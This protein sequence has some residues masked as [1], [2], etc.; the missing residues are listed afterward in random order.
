MAISFSY[1]FGVLEEH[2]QRHFLF[3]YPML[4]SIDLTTHV[5]G[6]DVTAQASASTHAGVLRTAPH[7]MGL[8][9]AV[10][11]RLLVGEPR[12][13]P[14]LLLLARDMEIQQVQALPYPVTP[15]QHRTGQLYCK[16]SRRVLAAAHCRPPL[17]LKCC[18][19]N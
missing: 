17:T 3:G 9:H 5:G 8:M 10:R 6:T 13:L 2:P 7:V 19:D 15:L 18:A 1:N 4:A 11:L 14:H 16:E 12:L